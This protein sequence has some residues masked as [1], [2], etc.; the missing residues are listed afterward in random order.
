[1][2]AVSQSSPLG[3]LPTCRGI[4]PSQPVSLCCYLGG[5]LGVTGQH[6]SLPFIA[7]LLGVAL[8]KFGGRVDGDPLTSFPAC[9]LSFAALSAQSPTAYIST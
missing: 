8:A 1:M 9:P 2:H 6:P 5:S 7:P 3:N 4:P